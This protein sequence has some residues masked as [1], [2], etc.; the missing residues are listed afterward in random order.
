MNK[1]DLTKEYNEEF[2]KENNRLKVGIKTED[3]D[4]L[5]KIDRTERKIFYFSVIC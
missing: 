1:E 3:L 5:K 4:S 2:K